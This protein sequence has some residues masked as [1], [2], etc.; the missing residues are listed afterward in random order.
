MVQELRGLILALLV[1]ALAVTLISNSAAVVR[2][3]WRSDPS[4]PEID[5][6]RRALRLVH[7]LHAIALLGLVCLLFFVKTSPPRP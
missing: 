7:V 1:A 3:I 4:T 5:R 2:V 6:A